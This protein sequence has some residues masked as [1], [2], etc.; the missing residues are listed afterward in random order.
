[1]SVTKSEVSLSHVVR[2]LHGD[3]PISAEATTSRTVVNNDAVRV[4]SFAMD[5]GQELTDHSA[6]R[7]VVVQVIDGDLT[8]T[9]AA[10]RHELTAGDVVYL[11]PSARHAVVAKTPCRFVLVMSMVEPA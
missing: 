5:R 10:A 11:A 8:F 3:L 7:P 9:V 2:G 6:P 1:M 4:V